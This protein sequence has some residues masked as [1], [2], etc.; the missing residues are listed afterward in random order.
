[1]IYNHILSQWLAE[2]FLYGSF[3]ATKLYS[4]VAIQI[5]VSSDTWYI[6]RRSNSGF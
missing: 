4:G 3:I 6:R 2:T 1:M 5:S